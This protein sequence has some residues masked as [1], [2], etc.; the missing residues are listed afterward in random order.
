MSGQPAP[1]SIHLKRLTKFAVIASLVVLGALSLPSFSRAQEGGVDIDETVQ[2]NPKE[3]EPIVSATVPDNAPP[4]TPILIR[5]NNN[6]Y[7]TT[8]RPQLVWQASSDYNGIASYEL[9]LNGVNLYG[10]LPPT[11]GTVVTSEYT[12][13]YDLVHDQYIL[14][15][16]T[17]I[18]DGTYTWKIKVFDTLNNWAESVTWTFTIDTQA[19]S[20]VVT[21]I[22][23]EEVSIS[24]QDISTIPITPLVLDDNEPLISATGEAFSAVEVTVLIPGDPTQVY[25]TTINENGLWSL[26]LGI[27]PRDVVITLN[28]EITDPAGNFSVLTGVQ[29]IIPSLVIVFPPASASPSPGATLEPG[30]SPPISLFPGATPILE[31]SPIPGTGPLIT[32]IYQPPREVIYNG[33]QELVESLPTGITTLLS[34]VPDGIKSGLLAAAPFSVALL[35]IAIPLT[36]AIAVATQFGWQLSPG[37]LLRLLQALGLIPAGKPQGIVYDTFTGRG[38]PFAVIT[39]RS[40]PGTADAI[41]ETVVT[42][43]SGIYRGLKL[44]AGCYTLE[45]AHQDYRFPSTQPRAAYL[46]VSDYYLGEEFSVK[47]NE[48]P[49][50]MIPV[51]P[52]QPGKRPSVA[53]KLRIFIASSSR[54]RDLLSLPLFVISGLLAIMFP[55]LINIL[56]F[57]LYCAIFSYKAVSWFRI[58]IVSGTVV[59]DLGVGVVDVVV[60]I[61]LSGSS[62]LEAIMLTDALGSFRHYGAK[63]TYQLQFNKTGYQWSTEASPL[64]AYEVDANQEPVV[65]VITMQPA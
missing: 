28:F 56:F 3:R 16:A 11:S 60:R 24:A 9:Y 41:L 42:D 49:L 36:T 8:S 65:V 33:F 53:T 57:G 44:L 22:G 61:R 15:P 52:L 37:I 10:G 19:P 13:T 5:P 39:V 48:E 18:P 27:L 23:D 58:P 4:V 12:L 7:V 29:F 17:G 32:I 38:V 51:D 34:F 63:N 14:V 59:N 30:S 25:N 1:G 26:Q 2:T 31:S 20:F 40:C 35:A 45:V 6:S 46:R 55:T 50:F 21:Q 47:E 54:L 43:S 64:A 62:E